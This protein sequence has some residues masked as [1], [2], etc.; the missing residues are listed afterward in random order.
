MGGRLG[1]KIRLLPL[2]KEVGRDVSGRFG[3]SQ[4]E[5]NVEHTGIIVT[6]SFDAGSASDWSLIPSER[7]CSQYIVTWVRIWEEEEAWRDRRYYNKRPLSG[8]YTAG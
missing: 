1:C 3:V 6:L 8:F 4:R 7:S 5:F 2:S